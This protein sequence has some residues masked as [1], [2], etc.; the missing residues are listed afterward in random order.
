[1]DL[2]HNQLISIAVLVKYP[3]RAYTDRD[4]ESTFEMVDYIFLIISVRAF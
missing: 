1:M 3:C 2:I 4:Y